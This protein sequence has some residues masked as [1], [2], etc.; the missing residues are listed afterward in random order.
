MNPT[1][2]SPYVLPALPRILITFCYNAGLLAAIGLSANYLFVLR[3]ALTG[4]ADRYVALRSR[5]RPLLS[6]VGVVLIIAAYADL[7]VT[8]ARSEA[9]PDY[10][11]AF[12]P[13]TMAHFVVAP[14]GD[15]DWISAGVLAVV[16]FALLVIAGAA[17]LASRSRR[18]AGHGVAAGLVFSVLG[19]VV[20]VL[21]TAS[22]AM[23]S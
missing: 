22:G 3:S 18:I 21:P 2:V 17:L 8:I 20:S 19:A 13:S 10:A 1:P 4:H 15:E 14:A 9:N 12:L 23:C 11:G 16:Q 7:A 5:L 6:I